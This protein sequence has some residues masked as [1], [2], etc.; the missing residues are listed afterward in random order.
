MKIY[1]KGRN[2]KVTPALRTYAEEKIGHLTHYL[3][4]I[5]DAHVTLRMER[6]LQIVDVVL[7]LKHF[8]IK[9]EE[10][11]PDM[12]ASIDLVRDR[13]EQQIRKYKTKHWSHHTRANGKLGSG[14]RRRAPSKT[15][16]GEVDDDESDKSFR[17]VRSKKIDIKKMD[18]QDAAHQ[19]ELLGH[20]FFLFVNN[21]TGAVNVLYKRRGGQLGLI[22]TVS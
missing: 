1:T 3:D 9:A 14:V 20:D 15:A 6:E 11:S 7:T 2:L 19:M 22:E 17:I 12:Y 8:L 13:L 4:Q 5:I 18:P 21:R 10:R 16:A